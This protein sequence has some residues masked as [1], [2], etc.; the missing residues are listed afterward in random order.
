MAIAN[1]AQQALYY[2]A[3]TAYGVQPD[4]A[5]PY[6]WT[7]FPFTGTS[8]ALTKDAIESE[9]LRGDRQIEDFR[10]G[11]KSIGGDITSELE[12]GAFDDIL[13]AVMCN[14]WAGNV[15]KTGTTRKSFLVERRFLDLATPEYHRY[16]GCEFNSLALSVSPNAMVTA[17]WTVV[18][19]DLALATTAIT[20]SQ[21]NPDVGEVPFDSFT[22]SITEG[23][24]S[25]ATV[26]SIE[27][28]IENGLEPLF[29]VGSTT[30]NR[31]SIGKSRVTGSLTTYFENKSLYEKF[32]NETESEIVLVLKDI[33]NNQYTIDLPN[34]K[35]NS[36]QPDVSGEG[37]I[38]VAMDFV[39]LYKGGSDVSNIVIT[40]VTA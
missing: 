2:K 5:D 18:G 25:I 15:L 26:T 16:S 31:P 39:A 3:E 17:T 30:T 10:H 24:T 36:G 28:T 21:Y 40:R 11:N 35:Y 34:I 20:N 22:G 7:P 32:I 14:D 33:D 6:T 12:Y 1:G 27:L 13:S 8:L 38:T 4:A 9:K 37:P 19:K 23:G 29:A